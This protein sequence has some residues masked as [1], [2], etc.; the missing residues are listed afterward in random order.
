[1]SDMTNTNA[2]VGL[3]LAGVFAVPVFSSILS[4]KK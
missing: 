2:W 4:K 3:M 1:M